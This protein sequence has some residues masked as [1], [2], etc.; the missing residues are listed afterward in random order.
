MPS[1]FDGS[2]HAKFVCVHLFFAERTL[3]LFM[4]PPR[5][6]VQMEVIVSALKREL[7]ASVSRGGRIAAERQWTLARPRERATAYDAQ[8][9]F[10]Q[11]VFLRFFHVLASKLDQIAE[12]M[13][14]LLVMNV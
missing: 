4:K 13:Q 10:I 14:L 12:L 8:V 11:G 3:W 5:D 7:A 9:V 1:F 2:V 6:A